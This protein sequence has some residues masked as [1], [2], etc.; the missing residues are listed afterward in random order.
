[1]EAFTLVLTAKDQAKLRKRCQLLM[2]GA[3]IR[4]N[5]AT[6]GSQA[7]EEAHAAV[8]DAAECLDLLDAAAARMREIVREAGARSWASKL[9]G[10]V[11]H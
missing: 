11:R 2:D 4:R 6:V 8:M 1:M 10:S 9:D 7:E 3:E 5:R